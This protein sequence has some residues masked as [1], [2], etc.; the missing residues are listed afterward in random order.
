[1]PA[2]SLATTQ[3]RAAPR[4]CPATLQLRVAFLAA[5]GASALRELLDNPSDRVSSALPWAALAPTLH[6]RLC[7]A[8]SRRASEAACAALA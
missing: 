7:L 4:R 3:H 6:C 8:P 5:D 1:M 2:L